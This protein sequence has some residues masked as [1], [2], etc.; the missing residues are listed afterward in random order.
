MELVVAFALA[1][2]PFHLL[3]I[4]TII[5]RCG[6]TGRASRRWTGAPGSAQSPCQRSQAAMRPRPSG[7]TFWCRPW[8]G[9]TLAVAAEAGT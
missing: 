1:A 2:W 6:S 5:N 9:K 7:W 8:G 3:H 4:V